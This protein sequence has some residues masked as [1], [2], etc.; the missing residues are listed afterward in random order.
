MASL[1]ADLTTV[2]DRKAR[3]LE[4]VL[5]IAAQTFSRRPFDLVSVIDI[6]EAAHCSTATIYEAYVNKENLF[7]EAMS[8]TLKTKGAPRFNPVDAP[9]SLDTILTYTEARAR[10]LAGPDQRGV[11]RTLSARPHM[12]KSL[13]GDVMT[14]EHD[15]VESVLLAEVRAGLAAGLLRRLDPEVI[16]YNIMAGAVYEPVVY[17]LMFGDD[18][19]VAF[20]ELVRKVFEPLVSP[21][22]RRQLQAYL[23]REAGDQGRGSG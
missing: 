18:T 5:D 22:G 19:P 1:R 14:T 21:A 13:V 4:R 10:Y 8:R 12:M 16:V 6:A 7:L 2:N 23:S 20:T 9:P 17:G 3:S 11:S 15:Y